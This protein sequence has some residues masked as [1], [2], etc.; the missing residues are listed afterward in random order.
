[1]PNDGEQQSPDPKGVTLPTPATGTRQRSI[2]P[3]Y[4]RVVEEFLYSSVNSLMRSEDSILNLMPLVQ[5]D[6]LPEEPAPAGTTTGASGQRFGTEISGFL[7]KGCVLSSDV[8]GWISMTW[9]AAQAGLR[10]LVPELYRSLGDM[11]ETSGRSI[12]ARG[13]PLSWDLYLDML[14]TMD[15]DFDDSG[16]IKN[17]VI[18]GHPSSIETIRMVPPTPDQIARGGSILSKKREEFNARRRVRRLD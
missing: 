3:D 9:E 2:L 11:L 15:I 10:E 8:D 12:D 17:L 14:E 4:D 1:V 13:K 5:V 7:G 6:H 16:N 18:V